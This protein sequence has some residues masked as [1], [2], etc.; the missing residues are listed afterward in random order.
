MAFRQHAFHPLLRLYLGVLLWLS[1]WFLLFPIWKMID[2]GIFWICNRAL[3]HS[4]RYLQ[5]VMAFLQT[6]GGDYTFDLFALSFFLLSRRYKPHI[7]YRHLGFIALWLLVSYLL[8]N[9]FL[10]QWLLCCRPSPA[11]V[12]EGA[13]SLASVIEWTKVKEACFHSF[14]SDHGCT[15]CLFLGFTRWLLDKSAFWYALA[16]TA[17]FLLVRLATGAHWFTDIVFGS[18]PFACITLGWL[19]YSPLAHVGGLHDRERT[20]AI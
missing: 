16:L 8:F 10:F 6:K 19:Y 11:A 9:A 18:V 4:P 2:E 7:S 1:A 3:E 17:P 14:P 5:H 12:F 15:V 13:F 20:S